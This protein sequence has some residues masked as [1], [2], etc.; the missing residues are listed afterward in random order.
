MAP[1]IRSA[2]YTTDQSNHYVE[3]DA[4]DQ[5]HP[6]YVVGSGHPVSIG[7]GVNGVLDNLISS[8]ALEAQPIFINRL[9]I[10]GIGYVTTL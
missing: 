7:T 8:L 4:I 3:F 6:S 10:Y 9:S 1:P 2:V 5:S